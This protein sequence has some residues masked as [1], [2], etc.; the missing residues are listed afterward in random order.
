[1]RKRLLFFG[2]VLLLAIPLALLLQ[3]WTREVLVVELW[4][5]VWVMRILLLSV[6]QTLLWILLLIAVLLIAVRSLVLRP[7]PR[8]ATA[9]EEAERPGQVRI[10]A[11]SIERTAEGEYFRWS[12][13]Q[14]VGE[15]ILDVLAYGERTTSERMKQRLRTGHLTLP[16]ELETYLLL[17]SSSGLRPAFSRP[18]SLFSRLKRL[19][20]A[21]RQPSGLDPALE[22]VIQF[23]EDQL[24]VHHDHRA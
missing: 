1:M 12:L 3:G 4:R 24:E 22:R 8:D 13:A 15:L 23:L 16:P 14:H 18:V 10:L 20:Q 9:Q 6:P 2:L 11:K 7:E 21:S 17:L 5:V 19:L